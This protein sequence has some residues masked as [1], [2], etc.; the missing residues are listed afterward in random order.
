MYPY[1]IAEQVAKEQHEDRLHQ[2]EQ[3]RLIS[4]LQSQQ[5]NRPEKMVGWVGSQLVAAGLKLQN[6]ASSS[7]P[8]G[9]AQQVYHAFVEIADIIAPANRE[10]QH[11][12]SNRRPRR[13]P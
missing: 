13:E 10:R 11:R 4:L 3:A 9:G 6:R 2:S 7:M 12:Q 1:Q 5:V 8:Q